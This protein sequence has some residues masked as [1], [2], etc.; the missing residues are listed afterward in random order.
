MEKLNINE[1]H[2][3]IPGAL[4]YYVGRGRDAKKNHI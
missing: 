2:T 3:A 4:L 1:N